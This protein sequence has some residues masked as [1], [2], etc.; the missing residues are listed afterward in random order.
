[1]FLLSTAVLP[2]DI[3]IYDLKSGN[4]NKLTNSLKIS[5]PLNIK[6]EPELV[7]YESFDNAKIPAFLYMPKN[8]FPN[9]TKL[10]AVLSIH[11][12]LCVKKDHLICMVD[13]ISIY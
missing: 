5:I 1:M 11:G 8:N 10:G 4:I 9:Q 12:G 13:C 2:Y 3:Y 6:I 7:T